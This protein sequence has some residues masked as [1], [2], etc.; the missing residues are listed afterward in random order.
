MI[1]LTYT[2]GFDLQQ[3]L[4]AIES[5][6]RAILTT[7]IT[8]KTER[9]LI[10]DGL[11]SRIS[12]SLHLSGEQ[13]AK[14]VITETLLKNPKKPT[15]REWTV[16]TLRDAYDTI[17]YEWSATQK[18]VSWRTLQS[19]AIS[20]N[21]ANISTPLS[22]SDSEGHGTLS[23]LQS[24][25]EHAIVQ[26]AIATAWLSLSQP[27]PSDRGKTGRLLGYLY[28]ARSGYD[29][30]G[31]IALEKRWITDRGPYDRAL[32]SI[33]ETGNL[34]RWIVFYAQSVQ[35]EYQSLESIVNAKSQLK[36]EPALILTDRQKEILRLVESPQATISNKIVQKHFVI[37]QIT[38]SR[39]LAKLASIGLL[40][41]QGKGR[42]VYYTKV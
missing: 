27:F 14:N 20:I 24:S 22:I 32:S 17:R 12:A 7:P 3:V 38:A 26:A 21:D 11:V 34:T 8:V 9:T 23:Y 5:S 28:L 35:G 4:T 33:T 25:T 6:R 18:D 16:L 15:L 31:Y 1:P 41:T 30:R 29:C 2:H 42:S 13:T 10:W 37:S 39:E 40:R 19:L 36:D